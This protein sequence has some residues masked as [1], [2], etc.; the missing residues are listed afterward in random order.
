MTNKS[1]LQTALTF[2]LKTIKELESL[3]EQDKDVKTPAQLEREQAI[4]EMTSC[5][6]HADYFSDSELSDIFCQ[7]LDAGYNNRKQG[8]ALNAYVDRLRGALKHL[9]HNL[10]SGAEMGLAIAFANANEIE[11]RSDEIKLMNSLQREMEN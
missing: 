10:A 3:I 8:K 11:K 1:Q 6:E 4:K 2:A 5:I 7:L 9:R